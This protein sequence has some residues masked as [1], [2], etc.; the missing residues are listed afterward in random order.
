M[1]GA[2]WVAVT[3]GNALVAVA[4]VFTASFLTVWAL[5]GATNR[6]AR[7]EED[8]AYTDL[9]TDASGAV[10]GVS[11]GRD[12]ASG[13]VI[14]ADG[15]IVTVAG[16]VVPERPITVTLQDSTHPAHVVGVDAAAGVALLQIPRDSLGAQEH[17]D[18]EQLRVGQEIIVL[19]HP[20][21]TSM[22]AVRDRVAVIERADLG[23][24]EVSE[25]LAPAAGYRRLRGALIMD[26]YG[27][28]VGMATGTPAPLGEIPRAIPLNR[29]TGVVDSALQ[30]PREEA[31]LDF[32][33]GPYPKD[34]RS[35]HAGAHDGGVWVDQV[36][37]VSGVGRGG[38]KKGDL[39]VRI[40]SI[41]VTSRAEMLA[42]MRNYRPN[43]RVTVTV[44]RGRE[45]KRLRV[46]ASPLPAVL[47]VAR[48][49]ADDIRPPLSGGRVSRPVEG[50][51]TRDPELPFR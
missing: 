33:D 29:I 38:L 9:L 24:R 1:G 46:T 40:D 32:K 48:D 49:T 5:I 34:V 39:L 45:T 12:S 31:F 14:R 44:V 22:A 35:A 23:R 42:R 26:S 6:G 7:T 2:D 8:E 10:V 30:A 51:R 15:L 25:I 27:R 11:A 4:V 19:A 20:R 21:P 37:S 43:A 17:G 47:G 16:L 36:D 18:I 28:T 50:A 3:R 13:W 41:A